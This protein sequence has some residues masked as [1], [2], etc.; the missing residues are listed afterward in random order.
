MPEYTYVAMARSGQRS[1]GNLTANSE[2]E[3]MSQ[4]DSRG[5]FPVS[6]AP[7]NAARQSFSFGRTTIKSRYMA[8]S[9]AQLA[10][11][12][13]SGVPLLRSLDILQRPRLQPARAQ[14]L[15]EH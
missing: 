8:A 14:I 15:R 5:L 12:L 13:Q 1:Q 11:L 3:A 7:I 2:R 10:D 6:I 9:Y 4:L